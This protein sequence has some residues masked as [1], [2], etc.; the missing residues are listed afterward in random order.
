MPQHPHAVSW[1]FAETATKQFPALLF[2]T[3]IDLA[4]NA[5]YCDR[6]AMEVMEGH[7]LALLLKS[8][9]VSALSLS[10]ALN[11]RNNIPRIY[12]QRL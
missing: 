3:C 11:Q 10:E 8:E 1:L 9:Q 4:Q 6:R 5:M 2:Q 12:A 7:Y